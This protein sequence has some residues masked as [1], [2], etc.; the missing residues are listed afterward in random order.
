M[1][2]C[3]STIPEL[4]HQR[5]QA[6]ACA[7]AYRRRLGPGTWIGTTWQELARQVASLS[8]GLQRCGLRPG[9][10]L[11][12]LARP[13]PEWLIT[14]L[15]GLHAGAVIVGVDPGAPPE[16]LAQVL[17]GAR[18]LFGAGV[19]LLARV[20]L[21]TLARLDFLV[22]G[23][24]VTEAPLHCP[25]F[26]WHDLAQEAPVAPTRCAAD[27]PATLI[28]TS[29]TT[30]TPKAIQYSHRQLLLACGAIAEA[31]PHFGP[32][33]DTICWL[34]MAHLFQRM[35]N[36]AALE[37]GVTICFVENPRE[38]L[39]CIREIE[40]AALVAVPQFLQKLYD[41]MQ[42]HLAEQPAW[43]RRLIQAAC[44]GR[45]RSLLS[46]V[47]HAVLD[48]F[49]LRR[50]RR[51]LGRRLRCLVTG[52]APT[53]AHVLDFFGQIG[54]PVLEAYGLSENAV[55]MATNRLDACRSGSVGRPFPH[56][57]LHFAPDGEILVRGPGVFNGY[58][59]EGPTPGQFTRDGFYRTGDLGRLDDDGFLYLSGRKH[60]LI[61]TAT[62]RR[63]APARVEAVYR[64]IPEIE[65]VVVV[66]NSRPFLVGLMSL[67]PDLREKAPDRVRH[68][69]QAAMDALA[70]QLAPAERLRRF[71]ILP[72]PLRVE[73]GEL[74]PTLK[75][76]R[77][78]IETRHA[79]LID[80]L[81]ARV[82][83]RE[84][85]VCHR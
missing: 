66:G 15:A 5:I 3:S 21:Q 69:I 57:E 36:L 7:I 74:T 39:D 40:P 11:A 34:P 29:G 61:K 25:A 50:L 75:L 52:T 65:H 2:T 37:R 12:I 9:D 28:Y 64:Q 8:A 1:S 72:E 54:M 63:I 19:D 27:D 67:R 85:E 35:L 47:R 53:P 20:P 71:A 60:D 48:R 81:Y 26:A 56:N 14:E 10:R 44:A 31:F 83:T 62:G 4:L 6:S 24:Q 76:R 79:G 41:G 84:R 82:P 30:G 38:I 58:C 18:A 33:D 77:R 42:R 78:C 23:D 55:P 17:A 68:R 49:I 16:Q 13:S 51:V 59:G 70:S 45:G 22:R 32:A 46:H 80:S 73:T 43:K